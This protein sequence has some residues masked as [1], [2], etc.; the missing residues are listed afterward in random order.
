MTELSAAVV[1]ED[2]RSLAEFGGLDAATVAMLGRA[3]DLVEDAEVVRQGPT[4][5]HR[6]TFRTDEETHMSE[7]FTPGPCC[8]MLSTQTCPAGEHPVWLVDSE[9]VHACPWCT[10]ERLRYDLDQYKQAGQVACEAAVRIDTAFSHGVPSGIDDPV[11]AG[12]WD[13]VLR[14]ARCGGSERVA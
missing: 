7:T 6:A 8:E 1:A 2:L 5:L 3:A 14:Y 11:T 13:R 10:I 9:H 4:E 12:D